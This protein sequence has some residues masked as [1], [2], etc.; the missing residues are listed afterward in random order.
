MNRA[1]ILLA[2]LGGGLALA[3][4]A[5]TSSHSDTGNLQPSPGPNPSAIQITRIV[6]TKPDDTQPV[7]LSDIDLSKLDPSDEHTFDSLFQ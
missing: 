3:T 1:R 5:C 6:A 7:S 2:L 4:L